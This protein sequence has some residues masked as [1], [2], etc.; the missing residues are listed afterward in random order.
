VQLSNH[1]ETGHK[2]N[3]VSVHG[4]TVIFNGLTPGA[5]KTVDVNYKTST[6]QKLQAIFKNGDPDQENT[7]FASILNPAWDDGLHRLR[8][9]TYIRTL[10]LWDESIY[11]TGP[12]PI[13]AVLKGGWVD[14]H[15]FYDP[16][17]GSNPTYTDNP[18]ILAAWWMTMPRYLGGMGIPDD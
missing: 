2:L 18:A 1:G 5:A 9:V 3:L 7:N 11:S 17:D 15:P 13:S 10:M 12:P 16:R 14:G 4:N 8:G 6:G